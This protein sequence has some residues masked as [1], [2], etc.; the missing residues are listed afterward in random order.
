MSAPNFEGK[1]IPIETLEP[2]IEY[3]EKQRQHLQTIMKL[4]EQNFFSE[5]IINKLALVPLMLIYKNVEKILRDNN[6]LNED[7]EEVK[8]TAPAALPQPPKVV[9]IEGTVSQPAE[10]EPEGQD[11]KKRKKKKNKKKKGAEM[12]KETE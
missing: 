10:Q 6:C 9:E 8:P 7:G 5:D 3:V 2:H 1:R 11:K 12:L 4:R